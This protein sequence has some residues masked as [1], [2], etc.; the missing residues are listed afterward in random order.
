MAGEIF[1]RIFNKNPKEFK[2]IAEVDSFVKNKTGHEIKIKSVDTNLCSTR[3]SIFPVKKVDA[4]K[5][6]D[7]KIKKYKL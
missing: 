1:Q 6:I 5:E 3:G 4:G 2:S 7:K